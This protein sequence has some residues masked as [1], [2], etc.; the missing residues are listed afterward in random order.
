MLLFSNPLFGIS[1]T[2]FLIWLWWMLV[3]YAQR[4][5]MKSPMWKFYVILVGILF[6]IVG[7]TIVGYLALVFQSS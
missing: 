1:Y 3:R 4:R 5:M 7:W 2:L 6:V